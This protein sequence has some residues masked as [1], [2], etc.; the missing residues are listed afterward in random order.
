MEELP[1]QNLGLVL[2]AFSFVCFVLA[3][4]PLG[5][6]HW[7]RLIAWGLA[8]LIASELFGGLR[9]LHYIG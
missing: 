8:F 3:G 4:V 5:S 7:N 6:A 1:M 2:L 9:A